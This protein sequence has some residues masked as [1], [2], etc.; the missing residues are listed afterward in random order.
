[1]GQLNGPSNGDWAVFAE[2]VVEERD[3]LASKLAL[4]RTECEELRSIVC[5]C[6]KSLDNGSGASERASLTFLANAP[7]E[8]WAE[9]QYLKEECR[10]LTQVID[11]LRTD[12]I[13]EVA[14]GN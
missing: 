12:N 11:K 14:D 2:K 3:A 4:A 1:M 9:I 7:A 5:N 8:V 13:T 6:L 10:K